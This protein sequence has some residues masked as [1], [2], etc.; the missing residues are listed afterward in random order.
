MHKSAF[1]IIAACTSLSSQSFAAEPSFNCSKATHEFE[2]L[3]CDDDDLAALDNSLA[4]LYNIVLKNASAA[5]QKR[6]KTEQI[7]WVKGRNDCWKT[8]D[9]HACIKG[10]YEAMI[11]VLKDR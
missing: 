5:A 10:E 11:S 7:G 6:L 8:D 1:L 2:K 4:S 9:K 3:I